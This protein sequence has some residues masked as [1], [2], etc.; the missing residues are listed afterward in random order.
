MP[1]GAPKQALFNF[2]TQ[3]SKVHLSRARCL[4]RFF[5]SWK[6]VL[7]GPMVKRWRA[8]SAPMVLLMVQKSQ[9]QPPSISKTLYFYRISTT[10]LNWF[11]RRISGLPS[12][13]SKNP[14]LNV[15]LL[16]HRGTSH[17]LAAKPWLGV[18]LVPRGSGDGKTGSTIGT[19]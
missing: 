6:R 18:L 10:N 14:R 11:S 12:T 17:S 7:I 2:N 13:V 4:R 3:N 1:W 8:E 9:G 15:E 19:P 16:Q 5:C